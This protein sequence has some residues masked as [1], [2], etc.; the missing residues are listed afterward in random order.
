MSGRWL[1]NSCCMAA[2][3]ALKATLGVSKEKPGEMGLVAVLYGLPGV[4]ESLRLI[5]LGSC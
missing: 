5:R 4:S 2:Q 1:D 3:V